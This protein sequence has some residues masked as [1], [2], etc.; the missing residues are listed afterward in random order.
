MKKCVLILAVCAVIG[1]F[2]ADLLTDIRDDASN[3]GVAAVVDQGSRPEEMVDGQ[4]VCGSIADDSAQVSNQCAPELQ[5]EEAVEEQLLSHEWIDESRPFTAEELAIPDHAGTI[6]CSGAGETVKVDIKGNLMIG[7]TTLLPLKMMRRISLT[8]EG[9]A[10]WGGALWSRCAITQPICAKDRGNQL[11]CQRPTAVHAVFRNV[12]RMR[13]V[14]Q[15]G[16]YG[17]FDLKQW[18]IIGCVREGCDGICR[19]GEKCRPGPSCT[20]NGK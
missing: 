9:R 4:L 1:C 16:G 7:L 19:Q 6:T 15:I 8:K 11:V 20:I 12:P 2:S 17:V 5:D 3:D 14:P 18:R 10:C 13:F